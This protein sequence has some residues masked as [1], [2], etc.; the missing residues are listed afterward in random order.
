MA[1]WTGV[2]AD[3]RP[4]EHSWDYSNVLA[5]RLL[6]KRSSAAYFNPK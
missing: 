2:Q 1:G 4:Y 6:R 5:S 3:R